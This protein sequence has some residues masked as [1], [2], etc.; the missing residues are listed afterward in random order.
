MKKNFILILL[1][2]FL[3]GTASLTG[4]TDLSDYDRDRVADAIADSLYSVTESQN[5]Q[6]DLIEDGLRRVTVL[7]PYSATYERDGDTETRLRDQV[8]V[9]VW[10]T[11]GAKETSV[12]SRSARYI[13]NRSEFHFEED[14]LVET[15]DGL[16]LFTD[17]LEWSQRDRTIYSPDFVIIVTLTDSITGYGLEGTDDLKDY[18][19]SRITGEFVLEQDRP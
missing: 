3:A 6:M 9:T 17:Y 11:T 14:V 16:R 4:C 10:D 19:L 15:P 2:I 12:E 5:I 1:V 8:N 18:S 13:A 7:A